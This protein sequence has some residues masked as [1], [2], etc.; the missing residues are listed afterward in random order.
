VAQLTHLVT[1]AIRLEGT[2]T[3]TPI[4]QWHRLTLLLKKR[5]KILFL[6]L[7][8]IT[9]AQARDIL[10]KVEE[11]TGVKPA[12]IYVTFVPQGVTRDQRSGVL[13]PTQDPNLKAK[14][15]QDQ[16]ELLLVT[17]EGSPIRV[18]VDGT[19]REKVFKV[20][21]DFRSGVT[22]VR[23]GRG[24]LPAAK[25]LYQWLVAPLEADLKAR[26]I[27][28]LTFLMD[29]HLR[30]IPMAALHDGQEFLVEKYSVGLMPSLSSVTPGIRTLKI[31]K[32]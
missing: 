21:D 29:T 18:R 8:Q 31:R 3:I 11:A 28:N 12:L 22:N 7:L 32:F 9:L 4:R 17:A 26:G 15:S 30:S 6:R 23:S 1:L 25:Q 2:Q 19:T 10:H 24:Y 5:R 16:L 27:Q 14:N 13:S 20:A